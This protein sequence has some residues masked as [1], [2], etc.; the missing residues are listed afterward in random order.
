MNGKKALNLLSAALTALALSSCVARVPQPPLQDAQMGIS[1]REAFLLG[2]NAASQD[3]LDEAEIFLNEASTGQLVRDYALFNLAVV[4]EKK[5]SL[6]S[7]LILHEI[8]L[9]DYGGSALVPLSRKRRAGLLMRLGRLSEA[10]GVFLAYASDNPHDAFTPE[11]LYKAMYLSVEL[12]EPRAA[13]EIAKRALTAYPDDVAAQRTTKLAAQKGWAEAIVLTEDESITATDALFAASR[14]ADAAKRYDEIRGLKDGKRR[15][16]ATLKLVDCLMR[17]KRY[18]EAER[19]LK[20]FL[21]AR[22]VVEFEA[23]ARYKLMVALV[24]QDKTVEAESLLEQLSGKS[25]KSEEHAKA[26]LLMG[27]AYEEDNNPA[28]AAQKYKKVVD[29]FASGAHRAEALWALGWASLRAGELTTAEKMFS[30][31]GREARSAY[32]LARALEAAA[33]FDEALKLYNGL[34]RSDSP[35]YCRLA[36]MRLAALPAGAAPLSAALPVALSEQAFEAPAIQ[37]SPSVISLSNDVRYETIKELLVLGLKEDASAEIA[38]LAKRSAASPDALREVSALFYEAEDYYRA[39]AS[40]KRYATAAKRDVRVMDAHLAYPPQVVEMIKDAPAEL[41]VDAYLVAAVAREESEFN[42]VAISGA[43]ALGMMQI[44][45]ATGRLI[46]KGKGI[47]GFDEAWL[48]DPMT[49]VRFGSWYLARLLER[50]DNKLHLAIAAYNAGP[51]AVEKWMKKLPE[52][53]DEFVES[54]PYAET[55]NY[56]KRVLGSYDAYLQ[57]ASVSGAHLAGNEGKR[58]EAGQGL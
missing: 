6:E 11:A 13:Q 30:E 16:Q 49:S 54:I 15:E 25:P 20:T 8:I 39:L 33:R 34:C 44:M 7:A 42:R 56:V 31:A 24:R 5:G 43:G 9:K 55:R 47:K 50:F 53:P 37:A 27:R 18:V 58:P 29:G 10:R 51:T 38:L 41:G 23:Q 45:P 1:T 36:K 22:H 21:T 17:L 19:E 28:K 48:F 40:Y 14:Y 35:Y 26:L 3:R 52:E 12:S 57:P 46:A 4:H 2:M 32:W